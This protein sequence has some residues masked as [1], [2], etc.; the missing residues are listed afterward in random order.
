M[1]SF[2]D[3][4]WK[5]AIWAGCA[6]VLVLGTG[7]FLYRHIHKQRIYAHLKADGIAALQ[8]GDYQAAVS[9]LR[10]YLAVY[11]DDQ[12][13]L[14]AYIHARPLVHVPGDH[15]HAAKDTIFALR[16]LISLENQS[17][18]DR[19]ALIKLCQSID[20]DTEAADAASELLTLAPDDKDAL[21]ARALSLARL[22]NWNA[23]LPAARQWAQA[24]PSD[25]DAQMTVLIA[26]HEL[27]TQQAELLGHASDLY[28]NHPDA[29]S[30]FLVGFALRLFER[31]PNQLTAEGKN[32]SQWFAAAAANPP[33]DAKFVRRLAEQFDRIG[34]FDDALALLQKVDSQNNCPGIT[35]DLMRRLWE[36]GAWDQIVARCKSADMSDSQVL[37]IYAVSLLKRGQQ[38]QAR[39]QRARLASR[40]DDLPAAAWAEVFDNAAGGGNLRQLTSACSMALEEDPG[41]APLHMI[42][43]EAHFAQRNTLFAVDELTSAAS[44]A[45]SWAL[46]P[47]RLAE[48][49]LRR[50]EI[51]AALSAAEEGLR[52]AWRDDVIR[53]PAVAIIAARI[54]FAGRSDRSV[55]IQSLY[56]LVDAVQKAMPGEPVTG[57]IQCALLAEAGHA[58]EARA[59]LRRLLDSAQPVD[60]PILI[61]L[62]RLSRSAHL[63]LE[64]QLY[65]R[66]ER[67][68]GL[69][70][71][72]AFEKSITLLV[73]GDRAEGWNLLYTL[74]RQ[75]LHPEQ[76]AWR[77]AMCS[78]LEASGDS[79]TFAAWTKLGDDMS[80][81]LPA[82]RAALGSIAAISDRAF[83][84]RTIGRLRKLSG[85]RAPEWRLARAHWLLSD[86]KS[87]QREVDEASAI[88]RDILQREPDSADAHW[89]AGSLKKKQNDLL[90]A[91]RELR[92]AADLDPAS[93]R[94]VLEL[95]PLLTEPSGVAELKQRLQCVADGPNATVP[96]LLQL[97]W[98][99][100]QSEAP[101]GAEFYY[102]RALA[103]QPDLTP[104][105]NNLAM[106]LLRT[107]EPAANQEALQLASTA[108]AREPQNASIM[109]TLA[110]AYQACGN[111][112]QAI[113]SISRAV[114]L[115]PE[116]LGYRVSQ[117]EWLT[118]SGQR[119]AAKNSLAT[120]DRIKLYS[121][122]VDPAL[123]QRLRVIRRQLE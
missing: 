81:D 112:P 118:A 95:V 29:R 26:M 99:D 27:R 55:N 16:H 44:S 39:M 109:D 122:K 7:A 38:E 98:L 86:P 101:V 9:D 90:G 105:Q 50:G 36:V 89:I 91:V 58:D 83:Q 4:N 21:A 60:E 76:A 56:R 2:I 18:D 11:L 33:A 30:A 42:C 69:T 46:P 13:A 116:N 93:P 65:Q 104:A 53:D 15:A 123:W 97:A 62:A 49:H 87:G 113:D 68:H 14:R 23:A 110:R 3:K 103:M 52:R 54:F 6:L 70:P 77:I 63:G 37:G 12:E 22:K 108:A 20:Q 40:R 31:Q 107:G 19:R 25:V 96:S 94:Y 100:Q 74:R 102:R 92:A 73:A 61:W 34:A 5:K 67:D 75:G 51:R 120:A 78:Y 57:Q 8:A 41:D 47:A 72:L 114:A 79:G 45:P 117:I 88:V 115:R 48:V 66:C 64:E 84:E 17:L 85:E 111:L 119:D 32:A 35:R 82:Q 1:S 28:K 80:D 121:Q 24:D 71:T 106:L 59:S 43:A 10:A